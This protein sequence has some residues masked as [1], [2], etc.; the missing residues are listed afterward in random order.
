LGRLLVVILGCG[1]LAGLT[2]WV[3]M[4]LHFD[5]P[6]PGW[7]RNGLAASFLLLTGLAVLALPWPAG[8]VAGAMLCGA[9]LL[10]WLQIPASNNRN[11][12]PEYAWLASV[13]RDSDRITVRNIRNFTYRTEA[14]VSQAYDDAT[15]DLAMLDT[16]DLVTSYWAGDEIAHVFVSFGFRDG[17]Y[18]ATSIET[19]RERGESYSTLAGFFRHY[20]LIY[21]VADE[22][23]LIG[24]RT[25]IRGERVYLYQL[26]LPPEM[27]RR[28]FVSYLD[29]V[30]ALESRPEFY[31]TLT[32]NCTT[33]VL[34]RAQAVSPTIAYNWRVLASGYAAEDA[35]RLGLLDQRLPFPELL[36]ASRIRRPPAAMAG[37][38]FS[39]EI[40]RRL[41]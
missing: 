30:A 12:A 14:D 35:Y 32:N 19:G 18:L 6:G 37:P 26:R 9:V 1:V 3:A 15:Y 40:R 2:V 16:K 21:V 23:D 27:V 5:G 4:A 25:D 33:G 31:N 34:G 41:D 8:A 11:W 20:E 24:L 10:W 38:D 17:R 7:L 36:Q 28:L 29:R 22:R 13:A 39:A